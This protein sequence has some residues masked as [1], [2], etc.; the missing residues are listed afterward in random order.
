[1]KAI[2]GAP[3]QRIVLKDRVSELIKDAILSGRLEPGDRI[4]EMK[5]A[6]GLGVGTT[7]VREALFELES[8]G[9]VTRL[10]NKGTFV[11]KLSPGDVE[12][13]LR[14]RRE[15]E[16]L[17]V[18]LLQQRAEPQNLDKLDAI[19][20]DLRAAAAEG[21]FQ[22]FYRADLEFH[23]TLW[24]LS[25]NR[26][27]AKA[28]D[29]TVVPLFA[30]FILKNSRESSDHLQASAQRHAEV[31]EAVRTGADA[32]KCMEAALEFFFEQEQELLFE[33]KSARA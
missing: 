15:L 30:F 32:R 29:I 21:N 20:A 12:E 17:A 33:E 19:V 3:L 1:M 23:R 13:I 11:T 31:I 18:E 6:N 24:Q 22:S 14:V 25:G 10:T 7:A 27:L 26:F 16:G 4:V 28:L 8:Q 5:L 9:F 2:N